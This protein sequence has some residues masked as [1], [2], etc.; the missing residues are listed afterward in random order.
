MTPFSCPKISCSKKFTSYNWPLK[1]IK[2]NYPEHLQAARLKNLDILSVPR[3]VKRLDHGE[4]NP[5]YD[6]VEDLDTFP[7]VERIENIVD[8]MTQLMP[9]LPQTEIFHGAG[10]PLIYYLAE[11]WENDAQGCLETNP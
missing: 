8:T 2:L 1:H 6:S 7:Y 10:T 3:W 9:P 4:C 11:P 5:I